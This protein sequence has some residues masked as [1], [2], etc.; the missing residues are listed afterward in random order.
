MGLGTIYTWGA[1]PPKES[2]RTRDKKKG[3]MIGRRGAKREKATT[4]C[5]TKGWLRIYRS[6]AGMNHAFVHKSVCAFRD[7]LSILLLD[8]SFL[9]TSTKRHRIDIKF[10][11]RC[12]ARRTTT[13]PSSGLMFPCSYA[14]GFC[15][16]A[17]PTFH[18][19]S[20]RFVRYACYKSRFSGE[21]SVEEK[22]NRPPVATKQIHQQHTT[23]G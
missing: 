10:S 19:L 14:R 7:S 3:Y 23:F 22:G 20:V 12:A 17:M 21:K 16:F 18:V 9:P 8:L 13:I 11:N 5:F 15:R 4:T 2:S 6:G 1:A